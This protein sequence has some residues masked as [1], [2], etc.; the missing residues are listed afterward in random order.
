MGFVCQWPEAEKLPQR[1]WVWV[2][3]KIALK[4]H[5]MYKDMGPVLTAL[6]VTPAEKPQQDV[7]T[8]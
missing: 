8:F 6:E 3:A 1:D 7:V 2:T 4:Y 5:K